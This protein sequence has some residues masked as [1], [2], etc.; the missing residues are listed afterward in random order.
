MSCPHESD[1]L[2][3]LYGEGDESHA[4]HVSTCE[5]CTALA[6]E[7][8]DVLGAVAPVA[9]ALPTAESLPSPANRS[10]WPVA[11]VAA[12]ALLVSLSVQRPPAPA[13]PQQP[14][15]MMALHDDLDL[16]LDALEAEF[17][18]ASLDLGT[19]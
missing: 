10:W 1:T 8:L 16:R 18:V 5:H 17:D 4:M 14:P 6:D 3:W 12:A 11:V 2:L 15:P 9:Q 13:E 19:L 7:H